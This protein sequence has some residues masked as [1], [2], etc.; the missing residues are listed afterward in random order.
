[1][2]TNRI[3]LAV[4][5]AIKLA[6]MALVVSG[7]ACAR[8]T[9]PVETSPPVAATQPQELPS[10][11]E[12]LD[13]R[14]AGWMASYHVPGVS[15]VGIEE[16]R[17]AWDRHYGVRRAGEPA[18]VDRSTVFEACSLSKPVFAY[19]VLK[20][21][22]RG[23]LDLDKPLVEYLG[24]PYLPDEPLHTRITA[25]MVLSHTSGL[26]NWRKGSGGALPVQFEPGTR[27]QYSG[28]GFLFLQ[29]VAEQITGVPVE[30]WMRQE[31]FDPLGITI[32]SYVWQNRY[33]ELAA[34]GHDSK[35]QAKQGRPLY[36]RA[37]VGFSLYCTAYEYAKF[38]VEI[39]KVDRSSEHS[40]SARSIE[41][42]LTRTSE[43]TGRKPI[44][45]GGKRESDIVHWG[46]G[47]AIDKTAG[48]D[49]I[50]HS[51]SNGTG[52]R[53][54]CE[55]DPKR[56]TGL[57]IMTNAEGGTKLWRRLMMTFGAP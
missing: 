16:R 41:A 2:K 20:L 50:Y 28:E 48:G 55:F 23:K 19:E 43:A 25:R 1:M 14:V 9:T 36:R 31:L 18:K 26:P 17:I 52:F 46:L 27:F 30:R 40:L 33:R 12:E 54:Y 6:L 34:A 49:R 53:C 37:N 15:I 10:I 8:T 39:L 44:D 38:L 29:R 4:G 5:Y 45:R 57:V 35:G 3:E 24:K 56:G 32:S 13:R 42:M 7:G 47:W 51:G 22:E 11:V 21:V